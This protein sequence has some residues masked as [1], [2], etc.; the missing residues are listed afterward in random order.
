M[1]RVTILALVALA[2]AGGLAPAQAA[3]FT[4]S[5]GRT[6]TLPETVTHVLPAGPPAA[7]AIY[8]VAPEK[9]TGWVRPLADEQKDFIAAPYRTLSVT[10]RLTGKEGD[11]GAAE[12]KAL[13]PDLIIDIGDLNPHYRALA[14]KIQGETGIPYVVLDGSIDQMPELYT[15]L[16]QLLGAQLRGDLLALQTA[17]N[18]AGV[19]ARKSSATRPGRIY[20]AQSRDAPA[21]G[22]MVGIAPEILATL[23]AVSFNGEHSAGGHG[24]VTPG[25]IA[26]YDPDVVIASTAEV[27]RQ[28]ATDPDWRAVPAVAAGKVYAVPGLPWGWLDTPPG[29]NR[30]IGLEWLSGLLYP[31]QPKRDLAAD[32]R[33]FYHG[34]YQVDLTDAQLQT[35][36][37]P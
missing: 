2:V 13:H 11:M 12:V 9:L 8:T 27:A 10:G 31:Q 23:G 7:V 5:L 32:V 19:A 15:Q 28:L 14:D 22:D 20:Y 18:L 24:N 37:A 4:D 30:L 36:L 6:V 33:A 17:S 26:L 21:M 25:Q 1:R 29:V 34:Y 3:E 35:L 16:S